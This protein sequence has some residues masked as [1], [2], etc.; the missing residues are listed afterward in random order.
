MNTIAARKELIEDAMKK[1]AEVK[2]LEWP[3]L[4]GFYATLLTSIAADRP[5]DTERVVSTILNAIESK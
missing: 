1:L 5:G 3:Y 2:L 4:A